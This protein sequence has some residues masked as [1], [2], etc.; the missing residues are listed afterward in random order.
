MIFRKTGIAVAVS[1]AA[2]LILATLLNLVSMTNETLANLSRFLLMNTYVEVESMFQNGE[3]YIAII[4]ALA[5][6]FVST[7]IGCLVFNRSE[8]K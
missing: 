4:T 8:V 6:M 1:I 7:V 5:Y 3:G 2:P